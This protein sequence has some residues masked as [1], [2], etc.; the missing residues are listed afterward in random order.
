MMLLSRSCAEKSMTQTVYALVYASRLRCN[1]QVSSQTHI[2]ASSALHDCVTMEIAHRGRQRKNMNIH[3]SARAADV[4]GQPIRG[5]AHLQAAS[6]LAHIHIHAAARRVALH[7]G[8][9]HAAGTWTGQ[10]QTDN[11][12]YMNQRVV[13]V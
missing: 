10:G 12:T 8:R 11:K 3:V 4:R 9:E 1:C 13:V 2:S 5:L 6:S 7:R